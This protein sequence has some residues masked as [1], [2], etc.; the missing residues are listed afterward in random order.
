MRSINQ[1][2]GDLSTWMVV[3]GILQG[4]VFGIKQAKYG[5]YGDIFS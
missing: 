5:A 4:S 3:L 2:V 1:I